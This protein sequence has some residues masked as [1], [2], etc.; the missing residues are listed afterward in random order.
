[1]QQSHFLKNDKYRGIQRYPLEK[2]WINCKFAILFQVG[3]NIRSPH[4]HMEKLH[5]PKWY[6]YKLISGFFHPNTDWVYNLWFTLLDWSM[7]SVAHTYDNYARFRRLSYIFSVLQDTCSYYPIAISIWI[8]PPMSKSWTT[9]SD[10]IMYVQPR[11]S[12]RVSI[13]TNWPRVDNGAIKF[14]KKPKVTEYFWWYDN[15]TS[16]WDEEL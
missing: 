15:A 14:K 9:R 13:S 6:P 5:C 1:M 2:C 16:A 12:S 10:G 7:Y 4:H 8:F 3:M 11:R